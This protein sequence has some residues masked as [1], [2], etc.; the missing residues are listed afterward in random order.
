MTQKT[1][2]CNILPL[3][4]SCKFYE[5]VWELTCMQ[6]ALSWETE[7]SIFKQRG[8]LGGFRPDRQTN[9]SH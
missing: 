8:E 3:Y 1:G 9:N 7:Y 2:W 4:C 5:A 6:V